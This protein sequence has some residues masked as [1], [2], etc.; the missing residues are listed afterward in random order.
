MS[1]P[2]PPL[3]TPV[4]PSPLLNLNVSVAVPPVRFSTP[5][6]VNVPLTLPALVPVMFHVLAA[7]GP[8]TVLAPEPPLKVV[9]PPVGSDDTDRVSLPVP[10]S[11]VSEVILLGD[12]NDRGRGEASDLAARQHGR[13]AGRVP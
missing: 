10:A 4:T 1:V 9:V 2:A 12:E 5:V 8:I 13:A 6:K 11:M 7:F 3:M